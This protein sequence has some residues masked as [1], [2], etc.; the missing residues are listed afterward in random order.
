MLRKTFG[1]QGEKTRAD[2]RKLHN[3]ELQDTYAS[4]N[5]WGNKERRMRSVGHVAC[6]ERR[7]Y[8]QGVAGNT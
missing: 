3:E 2:C 7:K 1:L 4:A 5:I 8:M 6:V